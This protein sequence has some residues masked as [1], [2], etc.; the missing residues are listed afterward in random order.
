MWSRARI[1]GSL[2]ILAAAGWSGAEVTLPEVISNGMVVQQD[3]EVPVWGW[4]APGEHVMVNMGTQTRETVAA[5]DGAWSVRIGPFRA[6]G[7]HVMSVTGTNTLE[8]KDVLVGE[9]WVCSGQSNM[10]WP[11]GQ[12]VTHGAEDAE[13]ADYPGIR[14]FQVAATPKGMPR[15]KAMK[16]LV[17]RAS[18]QPCNPKTARRFSAMGFYFGRDLHTRLEVPVG[19]IQVAAGGSHAEPWMSPDWFAESK[20]LREQQAVEG[21]VNEEKDGVGRFYNTMIVPIMPYGMRGVIWWQG[22]SNRRGSS[23]YHIFTELVRRWRAAWGQGDF[24]FLYVQLQSFGSPKGASGFRGN[25]SPQAKR[26][27]QRRAL[28]A[29]PNTG[30]A[31][32]CDITDGD[33]HPRNKGDVAA[34]LSLA[35][36]A[37]AYGE[38]VAHAGPMVKS[39]RREGDRLALEFD[40]AASGLASRDGDPREFE[41]LGAATGAAWTPVAARIDGDRLVIDVAGMASPLTVRYAWRSHPEGNLYNGDGLPASPFIVHEAEFAAERAAMDLEAL[42]DR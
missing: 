17:V 41:V 20:L 38:T 25:Y 31:V 21:A 18:W 40:H 27:A 32:C 7:P 11:L 5:D 2:L 23:Y 10:E 13:A 29:L 12:R 37:V 3:R 34:R 15:D 35:G 24:P 1:A 42:Y 26:D 19:L 39:L 36:R 9:V 14:L 33:L 8:V 4:G 22:E 16:D 6:G 28:A 30:M